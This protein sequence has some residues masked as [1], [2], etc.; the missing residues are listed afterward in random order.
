[1]GPV[2]EQIEQRLRAALQPVQLV[3]RDESHRHVG[4]AGHRPEGETHF[5]V[6][7]VSDAFAGINRVARQR[8]IHDALADLLATRIHALSIRA[9]A[10][11]EAP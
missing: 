6:E 5:G 4:H 1:M 11:G 7:V 10:P 9:R 8:L 2:M 3:V